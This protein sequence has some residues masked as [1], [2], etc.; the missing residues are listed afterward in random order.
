MTH[1]VSTPERGFTLV[2]VLIALTLMATLMVGLVAALATFGQTGSRLE[3]RSLA[4]DDAR[5][6]QGFLRQSLGAASARQHAR[7]GDLAQASWFVGEA[8][9]LE[10]LGLMPARHGVGGLSHLRLR[11][12]GGREHTRL[13]LDYRPYEGDDAGATAVEYSHQLAE[14]QISLEFAYRALGQDEWQSAWQEASVLPGHVLV[15]VQDDKLVWP[16][17]IVNIL[18]AQPVVDVN[19]PVSGQGPR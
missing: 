8:N 17:L 11:V 6:V 3:E 16:E 9:Q 12:E 14:G 2:E 7:D 10:W 15:R 5:L 19:Q 1:P 4:S 13:M 18:N